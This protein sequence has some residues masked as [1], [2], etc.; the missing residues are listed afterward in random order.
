M[1]PQKSENP[2][3]GGIHICIT[4]T[5]FYKDLDI[6]TDAA[7]QNGS[8]SDLYDKTLELVH[9]LGTA[10]YIAFRRNYECLKNSNKTSAAQS[11]YK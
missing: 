4:L 6:K 2:N 9:L 8:L 10:D 3:K 5:L 7:K 1:S 11:W